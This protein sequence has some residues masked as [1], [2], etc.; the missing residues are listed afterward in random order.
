MAIMVALYAGC[1]PIYLLGLDQTIYHQGGLTQAHFYAE[2]VR[3]SAAT[4][5]SQIDRLEGTLR[6]FRS[7]E[8]LRRMAA[9]DGRAIFNATAGGVLEVFERVN[10][11][12]IVGSEG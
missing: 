12:D 3:E 9:G 4:V 2:E 11:E 1:S 6:T 7:F 10:Y 5:R 8:A